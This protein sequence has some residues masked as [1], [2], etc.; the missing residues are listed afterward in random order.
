MMTR[1]KSGNAD[2]IRTGCQCGAVL[3]IVMWVTFGLVTV[4]IYLGHSM[5]FNYR[6]ASQFHA[7]N[8]AEQG[9]YGALRYFQYVLVN[10]EEAGNIPDSNNYNSQYFQIGD[11]TVYL[12]GRS[13]DSVMSSSEPVFGPIDE[14]SKININTAPFEVLELLPTITSEFAAAI[15]DW[16]DE[17]DDLTE[18]GAEASMYA[19]MDNSYAIKNGP[20]ETLEELRLVYGA[21]TEMLY[22]E[23]INQNGVLDPNENDG[24]LSPPM[25]NANGVLDF[26]IIE[27]LTVYSSEPEESQN[28]N[29]DDN[30]NNNPGDGGN[31]NNNNNGGGGAARLQQQPPNNNGSNT[32]TNSFKVNVNTASAVVL[33]CIPGMNETLAE[34]LVAARTGNTEP[35]PSMDWVRDVLEAE[36]LSQAEPYFTDKSYQFTLDL[37]AVGKN[38]D[39][40]RRVRFVIDNLDGSALVRY[41]RDMS[42][43]GWALGESIRLQL[44]NPNISPSS[45]SLS[46]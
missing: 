44:Q 37:A 7:G 9:I 26:G 36:V 2:G 14:A 3:I 18:N 22:G 13:S 38:G 16:R 45:S 12:I 32:T 46:R 33:A 8:Q 1:L 11:S 25:D 39:G 29:N 19:L 40:A 28:N 24:D 15:V 17:D 35:N 23:D 34:Q 6:G 43:F 5:F 42:R 21:T 30:N 20:F 41:R 10:N 4:A 31:N 27:Y